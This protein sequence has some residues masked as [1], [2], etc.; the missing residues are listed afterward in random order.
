MKPIIFLLGVSLHFGI[1]LWNNFQHS[2]YAYYRTRQEAPDAL[3]EIVQIGQHVFHHSIFR[4]YA[5]ISGN[6]MPYGFFAPNIGSQYITE[7]RLYDT[8]DSMRLTLSN[9]KLKNR[10]SL[11]RYSSF[12]RLFESLLKE[13]HRPDKH[14]SLE[15]AYGRAVAGSMALYLGKSDPAISKV[16]VSIYLYQEHDSLV[17]GTYFLIF[18]H[19]INL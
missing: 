11:N 14:T 15:Q 3:T 17:Q 10:E 6:D 5:K 2:Y 13:A 9:P 19:T 12:T 8:R 16:E 7:F 4:L 18:Q 1:I